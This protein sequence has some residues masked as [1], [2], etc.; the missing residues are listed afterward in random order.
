MEDVLNALLSIDDEDERY[1]AAFELARSE[2]RAVEW[3][4]GWCERL[5]DRSREVA[6]VILGRVCPQEGALDLPDRCREIIPLIERAACDPSPGVRLTAIYGL[7]HHAHPQTIWA[8]LTAVEAREADVRYAAT[9]ALGCFHGCMWDESTVHLKPAVTD[10]LLKLMDDVDDDV[11]DWATFGIHQGEHDTPETRARLWK[12]LDDTNYDVRGEAAEGLAKFGDRNLI[13]RLKVL[14]EDT[15]TLSPCFF[16][17]AYELDA[18]EL[19]PVMRQA[20]RRW[21]EW[22]QEPNVVIEGSISALEEGGS[23]YGTI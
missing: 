16:S 4:K 2:E 21:E 22:E 20:A 17:A 5:D 9:Y 3:A 15:D 23:R 12:A 10:A 8:I 7:G 11:R 6:Q 13:P 18:K 1:D 19:L 14:L